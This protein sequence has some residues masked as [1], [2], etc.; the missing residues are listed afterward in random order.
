MKNTV[1]LLAGLAEIGRK[2]L[3]RIISPFLV[4]ALAVIALAFPEKGEDPREE[5]EDFF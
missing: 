2:L 5:E 1:A 4:I 3:E